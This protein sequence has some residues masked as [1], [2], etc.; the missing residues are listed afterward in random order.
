MRSVQNRKDRQIAE[1]RLPVR[2]WDAAACEWRSY[3]RDRA[4]GLDHASR[5]CAPIVFPSGRAVLTFSLRENATDKFRRQVAQKCRP[6][7]AQ[8]FADHQTNRKPADDA[9]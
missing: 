9:L 4:G 3:H 8:I 1:W 2:S 5:R 6:Q 7:I